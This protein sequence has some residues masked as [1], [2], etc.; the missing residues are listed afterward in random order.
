MVL[1]T[2]TELESWVRDELDG[3]LAPDETVLLGT[4]VIAP[5]LKRWRDRLVLTDQRLIVLHPK[6]TR[7]VTETIALSSITDVEVTAKRWAQLTLAGRG[8]VREEF[9]LG[10]DEGQE[11]ADTIR[12]QLGRQKQAV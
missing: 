12:A 3:T 2:P 4:R 11:L 1:W 10:R 7:P 8:T 5:T 9:I 6:L